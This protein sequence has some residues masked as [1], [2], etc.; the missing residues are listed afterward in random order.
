MSFFLWCI[1]YL[2][3]FVGALFVA[4]RQQSLV[5]SIVVAHLFVLISIALLF[6]VGARVSSG[7]SVYS[8]GFL[9]VSLLFALLLLRGYGLV[10]VFSSVIQQYCILL[11]YLLLASTT[12]PWVA[13]VLT[14][15]VFALAHLIKRS[16][17]QWKLPITFLWGVLS[18]LLYFWLQDPFLNIAI[19]T[20]C[21]AVLISRG[22]L[23]QG[24]KI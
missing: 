21:G 4:R 13:M 15:L 19:H 10:Y 18:C 22:L 3:P 7:S 17:W 8:V 2:V 6:I 9:G 16:G 20:I 12:G 24:L 23:L 11:A 1:A 5:A 14:A